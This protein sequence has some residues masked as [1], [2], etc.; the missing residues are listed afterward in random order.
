MY[1]KTFTRLK[2][3]FRI[4]F[5]V[6]VVGLP[7]LE[8]QVVWGSNPDN[9]PERDRG[10]KYIRNFSRKDY[11]LQPQNWSIIQDKR[12]VI[13]VGNQGGLLEFD[14]VSWREI[15]VLY[16][17]VR[18]LAVADNGTNGTI[19]VGGMNEMGYLTPDSKGKLRYVS[20]IHHLDEKYKNFSLVWRTHRTPEGIYFCTTKFLFL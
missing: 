4:S 15:A 2:R 12:G 19:Y 8:S 18:S 14:G 9:I 17:T 1:S 6:I 3:F 20:L 13:Y 11:N 7:V 5:L 16:K 10:I